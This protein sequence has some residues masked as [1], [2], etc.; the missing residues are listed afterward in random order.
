MFPRHNISFCQDHLRWAPY[1][2]GQYAKNAESQ[3]KNAHNDKSFNSNCPTMACTGAKCLLKLASKLPPAA[4]PDDTANSQNRL[5]KQTAG[6]QK[7]KRFLKIASYPP[8]TTF[9]RRWKLKLVWLAAKVEGDLLPGCGWTRR[10]RPTGYTASAA[11]RKPG[12]TGAEGLKA[13]HVIQNMLMSTLNTL[14]RV[15]FGWIRVCCCS[16]QEADAAATGRE[17]SWEPRSWL[18]SKMSPCVSN[19]PLSLSLSL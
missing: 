1:L 11:A 15:V 18:D 3:V 14:C 10:A 19:Q 17:W 6:T 2:S 5:G 9:H 4:G 16:L 7:Y 12:Q 13:P 8:L